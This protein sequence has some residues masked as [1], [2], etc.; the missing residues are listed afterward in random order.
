[1]LTLT[2]ISSLLFSVASA[3]VIGQSQQPFV[4]D[5]TDLTTVLTVKKFAIDNMSDAKF[6]LHH[7]AAKALL[8]DA[9]YI[10]LREA[11]IE[12]RQQDICQFHGTTS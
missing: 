12:Q 3:A 5:T 9:S 7:V 8:G 10:V 6:H 1:M 11:E 2:A 4:S